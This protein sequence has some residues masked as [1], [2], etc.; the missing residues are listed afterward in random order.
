MK[1]LFLVCV[2]PSI[3][4]NEEP[5]AIDAWIE[6]AGSGRLIGN[7]LRGPSSATTVRVRRRERLVTDGPFAETKEIVVG[8][9]VI[10]CESQEEAVELAAAHPVAQFGSIEVR[11]F[12]A[13]EE[14]ME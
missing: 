5:G 4:P 10:E 7:A 6:R 13:D 9:D 3:E 1:Y 11:A 12:A 14:W 2:D 8:F